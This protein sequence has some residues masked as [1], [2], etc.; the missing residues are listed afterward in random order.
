MNDQAREQRIHRC[1]FG[2]ATMVIDW[3][4]DLTSETDKNETPI[5]EI[6]QFQIVPEASGFRGIV[7]CRHLKNEE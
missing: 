4:S 3:L 1:G 7:L 6:Q 5:H 2:S